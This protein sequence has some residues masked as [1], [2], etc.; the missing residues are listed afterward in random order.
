MATR[1][2]DAGPMERA[3][4]RLTTA[5]ESI[6]DPRARSCSIQESNEN[7]SATE[8]GPVEVR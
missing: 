4:M 6:T 3:K 8:S 2:F 7:N 5:L 1:E